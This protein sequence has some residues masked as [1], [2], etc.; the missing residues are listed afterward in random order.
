MPTVLSSSSLRRPDDHHVPAVALQRQRRRPADA[1]AAARDERN[2]A[3]SS[4]DHFSLDVLL[5][6]GRSLRQ[7][8]HPR[9]RIVRKAAV[10]VARSEAFSWDA[11]NRPTPAS[12]RTAPPGSR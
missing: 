5:K 4:H 6:F 1:G 11:G 2:L 3:L 12:R 7:G 8:P 9:Q 10:P